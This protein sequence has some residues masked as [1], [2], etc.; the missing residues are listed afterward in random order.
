MAVGAFL[1]QL[2]RAWGTK[3]LIGR[4]ALAALG[5]P[6]VVLAQQTSGMTA[7]EMLWMF[8]IVFGAFL[9]A[10]RG[11]PQ[12]LFDGFDEDEAVVGQ[13]QSLQR[14]FAVRV[15]SLAAVGT[16]GFIVFATLFLD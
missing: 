4:L 8:A 15:A 12:E 5:I 14:V 1:F 7:T 2:A 11:R 13:K 10:S 16:V 6:A 9:L 3:R